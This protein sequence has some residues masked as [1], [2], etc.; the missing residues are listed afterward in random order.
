MNIAKQKRGKR[1]EENLGISSDDTEVL[2]KLRNKYPDDA[3]YQK[4]SFKEAFERRSQEGINMNTAF[5]G[6]LSGRG[7]SISRS[8]A[9]DLDYGT[10]FVVEK[11][12]YY[13]LVDVSL[14]D[15]PGKHGV[16]VIHPDKNPV[17]QIMVEFQ[18]HKKRADFTYRQEQK[19][20]N[21]LVFEKMRQ[22]RLEATA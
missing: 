15:K 19:L 13:L 16:V 4:V 14:R 18:L 1:N 6:S 3:R 10:D 12:G 21:K 17:N 22:A 20:H 11:D 2:W 9:L 5:M 7:F 8:A